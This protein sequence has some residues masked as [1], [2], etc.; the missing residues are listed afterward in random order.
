M[1]AAAL[2]PDRCRD[3]YVAR[4]ARF[5]G[6]FYAGVTTTRIFCR[7]I[8]P[9]PRPRREHLRIFPSAAEAAAA[10]FRPCRRCRPEAAP[11]S[12][13]WSGTAATVA[14]A[15]KLID[16]GVLDREGVD[17][18]AERLGLGARQLRRLFSS[19]LGVSPRAAATRRRLERAR[20]LV[21][22]GRASMTDVALR[23]GFGSVRQFNAAMRSAFGAS[24]SALRRESQG[25]NPRA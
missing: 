3:A 23:A 1:D 19:H 20:A 2:D 14:R 11:G 18:L 13:A 25:R 7:P 16:A 9:A 6:R 5:D 17:A 22:E 15:L 12:A 10:G 24:P 8:C 4:D 21:V